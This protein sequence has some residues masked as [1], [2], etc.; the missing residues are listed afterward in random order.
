MAHELA[1]NAD[2]FMTMPLSGRVQICIKLA[3]RAQALAAAAQPSHQEFYLSIASE[4]LRLAA[5]MSKGVRGQ[6][7]QH[8][9][10]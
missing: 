5:E 6:D 9:E 1:F 3:Q 2:E 4:W 10:P 8:T 7:R